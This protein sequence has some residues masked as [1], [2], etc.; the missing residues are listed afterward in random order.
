MITRNVERLVRSSPNNQST[1]IIMLI[2][3]SQSTLRRWIALFVKKSICHCGDFC[4]CVQ[5]AYLLAKT[6]PL[7][8]LWCLYLS[9]VVD[10]LDRY[11]LT[12][13]STRIKT[14]IHSYL[15][16]AAIFWTRGEIDHIYLFICLQNSNAKK[17]YFDQTKWRGKFQ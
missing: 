12:S 5:L 6:F 13:Q 15:A 8:I 7:F 17:V 14:I 1:E 16:I 9:G 11:T 2:W 10:I 4:N 3:M